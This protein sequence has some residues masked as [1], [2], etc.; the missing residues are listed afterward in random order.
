MVPYFRGDV[1]STVF[2]LETE[3]FLQAHQ[4]LGFSGVAFDPGVTNVGLVD[5]RLSL[6]KWIDFLWILLS[7]L[8]DVRALEFLKKIDPPVLSNLIISIV[9]HTTCQI[10]FNP[11]L[12]AP[13]GWSQ[14][15]TKSPLTKFEIGTEN[16]TVGLWDMLWALRFGVY[17]SGSQSFWTPMTGV[18]LQGSIMLIFHILLSVNS[19][20]RINRS[21]DRPGFIG[22]TGSKAAGFIRLR[23]PAMPGIETLTA[24]ILANL[25]G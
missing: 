9:L 19:L 6:R 18:F 14:A 22:L 4:L 10:F 13:E 15:S 5:R 16:F 3:K 20:D 21:D 17:N 25:D 2:G 8:F 23:F 1:V 7:G 24:L 12:F 11:N